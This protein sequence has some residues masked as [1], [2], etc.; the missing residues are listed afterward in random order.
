MSSLLVKAFKVFT[1]PGKMVSV[2]TNVFG[3][4]IL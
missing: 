3:N 1:L 2:S 4:L